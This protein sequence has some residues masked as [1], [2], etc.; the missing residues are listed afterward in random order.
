MCKNTQ[1]KTCQRSSPLHTKKASEGQVVGRKKKIKIPKLELLYTLIRGET[2]YL[3]LYIK[4][5]DS[6]LV[7]DI[8]I[9]AQSIEEAVTVILNR[10]SE[11]GIKMEELGGLTKWKTI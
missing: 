9:R 4:T 6:C 11:I 7:P 5:N 8:T 1:H 3:Q 2:T 10:S